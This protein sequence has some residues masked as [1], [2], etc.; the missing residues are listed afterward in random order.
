[1]RFCTH[2]K[3]MSYYILHGAFFVSAQDVVLAFS[4]PSG[5]RCCLGIGINN[6]QKRMQRKKVV[7]FNSLDRPKGTTITVKRKYGGNNDSHND[8]DSDESQ[9]AASEEPVQ[10]IKSSGGRQHG[11]DDSND[12]L[13][14]LEDKLAK[15]SPNTASA[16]DPL[17]NVQI[18][19]AMQQLVLGSP[20]NHPA[21]TMIKAALAKGRVK[22]HF[23]ALFLPDTFLNNSVSFKAVTAGHVDEERTVELDSK[24]KNLDEVVDESGKG[25]GAG[26]IIDY[27][28]DSP[29]TFDSKEAAFAVELVNTDADMLGEDIECTKLTSI[30]TKINPSDKS[31]ELLTRPE[32]RGVVSNIFHRFAVKGAFAALTGSP[33]IGKSWTLFYALQQ[34]LL[35]DGATVLF[36]FQKRDKAVMYLRRN[37]KVYAW[38]SISK[39]SA[40]SSLF[41]RLDLLVLLDP[42]DVGQGGADFLLG[43]MKLLYA[44]SNNNDHF[45]GAA[46][47][48]EGKMKAFLGPPLDRE[49]HVILA[50]L[51][52][53]LEQDVIEERKRNV[54]NL[55]RYILEETEYIERLKNT[56]EALFDCALDSELMVRALWAQGMSNGRLT[57]PGTLFLMFPLRP[58][59]SS[60]VGYEGQNIQYREP[61]VLAANE[62]VHDAILKVGRYVM[63]Y[64][65]G[66]VSG[67]EYTRMGMEAK[68]LFIDDLLNPNGMVMKRYLQTSEEDWKESE[69]VVKSGMVARKGVTIDEICDAVLS[70]L[71]VVAKLAEGS[72][73][74]IDAAGPGRKVYHVTVT[75]GHSM[76]FKAM[77]NLCRKAGFIDEAGNIVPENAAD[78]LDFYWVGPQRL[79]DSW[80]KKPSYLFARDDDSNLELVKKCL[81]IHVNQFILPMTIDPPVTF[82]QWETQKHKLCG[83][84]E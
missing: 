5:S 14:Q 60:S 42:R 9:Q 41:R 16:N 71:N 80:R 65:W 6:Q 26:T 68:K 70:K 52:P 21:H 38:T 28:V 74:Q 72:V 64:Y 58:A 39:Q 54:G 37:N 43:S 84:S 7:F 82:S 18:N 31:C 66:L 24:A 22:P 33:G 15:D 1:M 19:R 10:L 23:H 61:I 4:H 30:P 11:E 77:E 50:R 48:N 2:A 81:E 57:I 40:G 45:K 75:D 56:Y 32:S 46:K 78:K 3:S 13:M 34:A 69:L 44:A 29:W 59:E 47:K 83:D 36:F 17:V 20:K 76:S 67:A 49:L 8:G 12:A 35:Y 55:I 63:L 25:S 53:H 73:I 62:D 51:D 27:Q 79:G